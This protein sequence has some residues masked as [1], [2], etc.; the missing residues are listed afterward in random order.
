[1]RAHPLG[2]AVFVIAMLA[3][4]T[5]RIATAQAKAQP[6]YVAAEIDV[7]DPAVFA[8]YSERQGKLVA[9]YGGKF[10]VRGGEMVEINGAMPKRFTLYVFDSMDKV[11]AW[12][13]DPEQKELNA[14]RDKA[15]TFRAF[16]AE[17]CSDCAAFNA[18]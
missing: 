14:L 18:K 12:K 2:V 16:A 6:A 8:Q 11:K 17:G 13:N 5:P 10:M 15:S 9:K 7:H 1:M 4:G 3:V